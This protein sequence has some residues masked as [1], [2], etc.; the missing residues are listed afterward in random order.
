MTYS[1]PLSCSLQARRKVTQRN[2]IEEITDRTGVAII[3]RGV[4]VPAG[5]KLEPGERK[6]HLLIEGKDDMSV[7]QA[8]LE[9]QRMLEEETIRIGAANVAGPSGRY[10]VI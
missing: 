8:K 6:L 2:S 5:K 10:S 1:C 3:S 4:F 7:R 9:I